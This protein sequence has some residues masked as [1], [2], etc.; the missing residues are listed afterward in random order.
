MDEE[1]YKTFV[2]KEREELEL[3]RA[4]TVDFVQPGE[5]QPE[6]E[7]GFKSQNSNSG[8]NGLV[9]RS[10]R[11]CRGKEGYFSYELA[12]KP[13]Q[14]MYLRVTYFGGDRSLH[15]DGK[16]YKREFEILIDGSVIAHQKLEGGSSPDGTFE[17]CYEIPAALTEGK[18]KVGVTFSAEEG[19][20]AGGVYGVRMI[21][22]NQ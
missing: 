17:V 3:L 1:A 5:Q 7:H 9:Q 16:V 12:V 20:I 4:I 13:D 10:W 21:N 22:T 18:E 15:M 2:D 6:V 19:K 11:D 14:Q 8:Y